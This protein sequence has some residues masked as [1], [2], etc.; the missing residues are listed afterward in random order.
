MLSLRDEMSLLLQK[1]LDRLTALERYEETL[2][3]TPFAS[4]G[5]KLIPVINMFLNYFF[6]CYS[7]YL[8]CSG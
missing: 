6:Y 5:D 7:L 4:S 3:D 8:S 1:L 2:I